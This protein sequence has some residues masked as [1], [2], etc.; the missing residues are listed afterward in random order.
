MVAEITL[1][2]LPIQTGLKIQNT[3]GES[4]IFKAHP[5]QV[6]SFSRGCCFSLANRGRIN[7]DGFVN[8]QDYTNEDDAPLIAVIGD[9]YIEAQMVP[10]DETVHGRLASHLQN[11]ARVFSFAF[12][13]A[14]LSQ[15]LVWARYAKEKYQP[16]AYV[17]N[18]VGNDFDESLLSYKNADGFH[19]FKEGEDGL[20]LSLVEFRVSPLG[21]IVR[22]SALLQYLVNNLHAHLSLLSLAKSLGRL[23][24]VA[25]AGEQST[26]VKYVGNTSASTD[27]RRIADS[28][29]AIE[30]F[31]RML[32][33][34]TGVQ[35]DRILIIVDGL[36]QKVYGEISAD[37]ASQSYFG[38]MRN[39]IINRATREGY[40][41]VD[42]DGEFEIAYD[43]DRQKFEF[44]NDYHWNAH[45]HNIAYKAI[46]ASD[47]YAYL[48]LGRR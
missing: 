6:Y 1:R 48:P 34:N 24:G 35:K 30:A 38:V 18:V 43:R 19:Y 41:V 27:G 7:N 45:G 12:S 40:A 11:E 39:I 9:S 32:P 13:G 37:Q 21:K 10:F 31:L 4:P 47:W 29:M 33:D 3:T 46:L 36:R 8:E 26:D 23:I 2:L 42:L 5:N 17:F 20:E 16:Q 22:A 14:P 28:S 44:D 15:Y 25:E